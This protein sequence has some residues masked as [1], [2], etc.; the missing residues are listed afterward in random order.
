MCVCLRRSLALNAARPAAVWCVVALRWWW[1]VVLLLLVCYMSDRLIYMYARMLIATDGTEQRARVCN[2]DQKW[3][4]VYAGCEH[5]AA[6]LCYTHGIALPDERV[7][8][9]RK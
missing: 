4:I 9:A 3:I 8:Q 2:Y 6:H 7:Q 1:G 5:C